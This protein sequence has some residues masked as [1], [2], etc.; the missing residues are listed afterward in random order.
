[1]NQVT[2]QYLAAFTLFTSIAG[3]SGDNQYYNKNKWRI[4]GDYDFM[5]LKA[6]PHEIRE[7]TYQERKDSL[8]PLIVKNLHNYYSYTFDRDG[9]LLS[10]SLYFND[11]A[12]MVSTSRYS[13]EGYF[14]KTWTVRKGIA[15]TS[16]VVCIPI[17]KGR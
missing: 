6:A 4:L 16:R 14:E 15:D 7:F 8:I 9:N 10:E 3:C 17:G 13:G 2:I 5:T 11:T 1:M 12:T